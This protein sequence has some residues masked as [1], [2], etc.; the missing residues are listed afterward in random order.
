MYIKNNSSEPVVASCFFPSL[1]KGENK[2]IHPG[3]SVQVLGPPIAKIEGRICYA[4]ETGEITCHDNTNNQDRFFI[5]KGHPSIIDKIKVRII[6]RHHLD[7]ENCP[8]K[9]CLWNGDQQ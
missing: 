2:L 5:A 4:V 9:Q 1:G 8:D 3:T 7:A 6:I